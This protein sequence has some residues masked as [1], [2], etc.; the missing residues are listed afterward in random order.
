MSPLSLLNEM[1]SRWSVWAAG[2]LVDGAL[3]LLLAGLVAV[4]AGRRLMPRLMAVL[5][6]LVLL[7]CALPLPMTL[8]ILKNVPTMAAAGAGSGKESLPELVSAL[9]ATREGVPSV[10]LAPLPPR[11]TASAWVFLLWLAG[12]AAG[13]ARLA[14]WWRRTRRLIQEAKPVDP[15]AIPEWT[16]L[17]E[18]AT[19]RVPREVRV[20]P[21]LRSPAVTGWRRPVLLLPEGLAE[22]MPADQWRWV[23]AHEL[24]HA[25]GGDAAWQWFELVMRTLLFFNPAVWIASAQSARWREA[26]CDEEAIRLADVSRPRAADGF[27]CLIEWA[28]ARPASLVA[29]HGFGG[30]VREARA[31]IHALLRERPLLLRHRWQAALALLAA[32]L[33]LPSPR[34]GRAQAEPANTS[35][36]RVAELERRVAELEGQLRRKS[37][38]EKLLENAKLRAHQREQADSRLFNADQLREIERLYQDAKRQND[39]AG[40]EAGFQSLFERFPKANRSGCALI[41]L[42]RLKQGAEREALLHRAMAEHSDAYFLDATSVG[43]VA[44]LMLAQD[45]IAAG[46]ETEAQRWRAEIDANFAEELDFGAVPLMDILQT[47]LPKP[48][49]SALPSNTTPPTQP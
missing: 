12:V 3:A 44:R 43:G 11:L 15:A 20:S 47:A 37:R 18:R 48:R 13:G 24:A 28:Q 31:R 17:I 35:A 16:S 26:A 36:E 29:A 21:R 34:L 45:A 41:L 2:S 46:R 22:Q 42:A 4:L 1:A 9:V 39:T 32:A 33:V 49:T 5:F 40:M 7:K 14:W 30:C 6:S 23:L 25:R 19:G 10:T 38:L 27:V 8:P